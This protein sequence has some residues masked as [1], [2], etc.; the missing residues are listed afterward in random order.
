MAIRQANK[1]D[2]PQIFDMLRHYRDAG[3]IKGLDDL[4][5]EETPLKIMTYILAG[6]GIALVSETNSKLTGML[7]AIKTPYLWDSNKYIMN[8]IVYW[9]EPEHRGSTA[10]YRILNAYITECDSLKENEQI[11]NYTLSQMDGQ[12]LNYSRFGFKRVEETWSQ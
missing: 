6:G 5:E 2:I 4:I 10:G 1:F 8:E 3:T 11:I 9:V 7:L 12:Q